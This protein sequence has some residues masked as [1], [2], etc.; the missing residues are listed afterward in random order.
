MEYQP[1]KAAGKVVQLGE[2]VAVTSWE[3]LNDD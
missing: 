2:G 1:K 3:S